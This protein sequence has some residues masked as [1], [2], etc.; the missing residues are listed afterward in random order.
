MT[1]EQSLQ[2]SMDT[3]RALAVVRPAIDAAGRLLL[4]VLGSGHKVLICGNGGAAAEAQ[5]FA[6]ELVARY[7]GNRRSLPAIAL[8]AD[9][10]LLTAMVNDFGA[11]AVF[12][13]QIE[14]LAQPGDAVVVLSTSG[15]SPN[16]VAALDAARRCGVASIALL[17]R[18]GG[19]CTGRATVDVI[20]PGERTASIQEA[21]LFLIHHFCEEIEAAFPP[22]RDPA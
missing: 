7:L 17:G 11:D 12:A 4:D 18:G 2:Q 16:I 19:A 1:F 15:K 21:F 13:R 6:T 10:A 20:V 8:N 14:G 3:L 22:A 5:H 9:G